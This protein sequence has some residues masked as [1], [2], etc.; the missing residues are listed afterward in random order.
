M[1]SKKLNK[2]LSDWHQLRAR[3]WWCCLVMMNRWGPCRPNVHTSLTAGDLTLYVTLY[4][5][6]CPRSL[7][8]HPAAHSFSHCLHFMAPCSRQ[9]NNASRT[10]HNTTSMKTISLLLQLLHYHLSPVNYKIMAPMD[11]VMNSPPYNFITGLI[12][13]LSVINTLTVNTCKL[14][15]M[16]T[17]WS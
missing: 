11:D 16:F 14:Y 4:P 2:V 13:H 5:A 7:L 1:Y 15:N 17:L 6:M 9:L 3:L 10:T 12:F 8:L